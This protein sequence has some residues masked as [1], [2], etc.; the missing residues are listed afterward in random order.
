MAVNGRKKLG[1]KLES[2]APSYV[3]Q[4]CLERVFKDDQV[5]LAVF[6]FKYFFIIEI[7]PVIK[8]INAF[9]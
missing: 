4:M 2:Q 5:P 3:N 9:L 8:C 7:A 1:C 6:V